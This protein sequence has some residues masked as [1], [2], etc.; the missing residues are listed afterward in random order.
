MPV[1]R[2]RSFLLRAA[3]YFCAPTSVLGLNLAK[4][5]NLAR[6]SNLLNHQRVHAL[7]GDK[8]GGRHALERMAALVRQ[9]GSP[10]LKS[11]LRAYSVLCGPAVAAG[12]RLA[13]VSHTHLAEIPVFAR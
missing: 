12:Q 3:R 8:S 1:M 11:T 4:P 13:L 7:R 2:W 10:P 5:K 9:C 6:E